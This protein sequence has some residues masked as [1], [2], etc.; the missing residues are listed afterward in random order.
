MLVV[1][2]ER[3]L[4]HDTGPFHPER[5]DRLRAA[6]SGVRDVDPEL[7][8][9]AALPRRA[10]R[11]ELETVHTPAMIDRVVA[12]ASQGGGRLD[13]DTAMGPAS[14]EAATRAAGA[15]LTAVAASITTDSSCSRSLSP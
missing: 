12:L 15:V 14:F 1:T 11:F 3:F 8:S 5:P 9:G 13:P 4:D 2:D 6:L 7:L 10:E